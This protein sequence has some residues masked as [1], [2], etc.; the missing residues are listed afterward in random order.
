MFK[1]FFAG[2]D[3]SLCYH[4]VL[5]IG[6]I[7]KPARI[8]GSRVSASGPN[9]ELFLVIN[10]LNSECWTDR[11]SNVWRVP[12]NRSFWIVFFVRKLTTIVNTLLPPTERGM[13]CVRALWGVCCFTKTQFPVR[14]HVR[15]MSCWRQTAES[16]KKKIKN[17]RMILNTVYRSKQKQ[18]ILHSAVTN[19]SALFIQTHTSA[20]PS[21][22]EAVLPNFVQ[23]RDLFTW[24]SW[25]KNKVNK[26]W[27][28]K[29]NVAYHRL[30][31]LCW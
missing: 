10:K 19:T 13:M 28:T 12:P 11:W 17:N 3:G 25:A 7:V 21:H 24:S 20:K 15:R 23:V 2:D 16:E 26:M 5:P 1:R 4:V 9:D 29:L 18:E 14:T 31:W 6:S 30:T 22:G 8:R 27:G